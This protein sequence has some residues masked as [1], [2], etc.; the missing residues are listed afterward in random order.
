MPS[1]GPAR[2]NRLFLF[3]EALRAHHKAS[4][5]IGVDE[6]GRGPLAGPVVAAAVLLGPGNPASLKAVRD[7]KALAPRRREDL[8]TAIRACALGV[9][10]GWALPREIDSRNI[11][12]AT[13]LAMRRAVSRLDLRGRPA[14]LVVVDGNHAVPGLSH[15]QKALVKGDAFSLA[16]ACASVVAKVVRDRWMER[17]D[18]LHPGYGFSVHKGYGTADHLSALD[19]LGPS[20]VHRLSFEP[21]AQARLCLAP[22]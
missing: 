20:S 2:K 15:S 5:L 10:V 21:V 13:F 18:R 8:F 22:E 12:Q 7:S 3:D 4:L 6:A 17:L 1:P 16:V 11:L 14:P 9:G 19:R